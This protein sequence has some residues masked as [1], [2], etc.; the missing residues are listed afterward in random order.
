MHSRRRLVRVGLAAVTTTALAAAVGGTGHT[1]ARFSDSATVSGDASAGVWAPGP[2]DRCL[3][4]HRKHEDCRVVRPE[5][6]PATL[7][8]KAPTSTAS[9][10]PHADA[11]ATDP[12]E[13]SPAGHDPKLQIPAPTPNGASPTNSPGT[14]CPTAAPSPTQPAEPAPEID[15]TA[16][17]DPLCPVIPQSGATAS[18]PERG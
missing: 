10:S 2:P 11:P 17:A 18:P 15:G 16:T 7:S 4:P 9:T 8:P 5:H 12:A 13:A 1:Y 6:D 14:P 3:P